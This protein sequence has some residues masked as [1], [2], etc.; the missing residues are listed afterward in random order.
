MTVLFLYTKYTKDFGKRMDR[1]F[2]KNKLFSKNHQTSA[3]DRSAALLGSHKRIFVRLRHRT[4]LYRT[5]EDTLRPRTELLLLPRGPGVLPH[6]LL[7]GGGHQPGPCVLLLCGGLSAVL[8]RAV[9]PVCLWLAVPLRTGTGPAVQNSF[10]EEVE[11][12]ARGPVAPIP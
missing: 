5:N 1:Q 10:C 11:K 6:R 9:W 2:L 12:A 8:R 3:A 4:D 7:P